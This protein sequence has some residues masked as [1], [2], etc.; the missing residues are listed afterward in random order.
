MVK[1]FFFPAGDGI[2][3]FF[4][5][6]GLGDVYKEKVVIMAVFAYY[7]V[8]LMVNHAPARSVTLPITMREIYMAFP[9]GS[10]I[11]ILYSIEIIA[12]NLVGFAHGGE[13]PALP[14]R[15]KGGDAE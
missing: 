13:L 7:S 2:R 8:N 4:L 10:A 6:R 11:L 9:I 5:A 14:G 1:I 15:E 12:R 3:G